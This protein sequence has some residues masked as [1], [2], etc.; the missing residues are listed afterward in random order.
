[1]ALFSLLVARIDDGVFQRKDDLVISAIVVAQVEDNVLV[2]AFQVCLN[3]LGKLRHRRVPT[4]TDVVLDEVGVL[5]QL[6]RPVV[7]L[8]LVARLGNCLSL[9]RNH[10]AALVPVVGGGQL[11]GLFRTVL[12]L[13]R[14]RDRLA[15]LCNLQIFQCAAPRQRL[16]DKVP[17]PAVGFIGDDL[18][19]PL[20]RLVDGEVID[21]GHPHAEVLLVFLVQL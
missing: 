3:L 10:L 19:R 6:G 1:M 14:H 4:S 5:V 8:A 15:L 20:H 12:H 2:A 9:E 18:P 11:E 16:R 17:E 7:G 13:H 21:G